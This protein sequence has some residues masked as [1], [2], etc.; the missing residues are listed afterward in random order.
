[1]QSAGKVRFDETLQ[2]TPAQGNSGKKQKLRHSETEELQL[3]K[4]YLDLEM[5]DGKIRQVLAAVDT[6][7]NVTFVNKAAS[8]IRP[9]RRGESR[10]VHGFNG[11]AVVTV[12]VQACN[13]H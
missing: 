6:Q 7:S 11:H 4:V 13:H 2:K 3:V 5:P 9:W 10:I 1:M 8:V 12:K